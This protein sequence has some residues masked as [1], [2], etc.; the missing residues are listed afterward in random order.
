MITVVD[1][2]GNVLYRA[3]NPEIKGDSMLWLPIV[4]NCLEKKSLQLSTELMSI[5]NILRE[6][7]NLA[8]RVKMEIIK[9]PLSYEPGE[10]Q[11][12]D[13]MVM[14]A[15]YPLYDKKKNLLGAIV[16][17]VLLNKDNTIV[18]KSK[19]NHISGGKVQRPRYGCG[20]H[21]SGWCKN[22]HQRY[23]QREQE[24]YR[25]DLVQGGL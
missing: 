23:D 6:N 5:K 12:S 19:R 21:I 11:L 25:Y 24:G 10:K 4:K 1:A 17:G 2:R 8:E 18:D 3:G 9:I 20:N 15:A 7:P 14:M 16:G 22:I 13:G